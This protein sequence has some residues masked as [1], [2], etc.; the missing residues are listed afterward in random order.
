MHLWWCDL[1]CRDD[2]R[3]A[4][5]SDTINGKWCSKD[6]ISRS[7]SNSIT[8]DCVLY[9]RSLM[10]VLLVRFG[11]KHTIWNETDLNERNPFRWLCDKFPEKLVIGITQTVQKGNQNN[12]I[13]F[14][15]ITQSKTF[16]NLCP[17]VTWALIVQRIWSYPNTTEATTVNTDSI[18][19]RLRGFTRRS[20][21]KISS[22]YSATQSPPEV[23]TDNMENLHL[24]SPFHNHI[25]Y[26]M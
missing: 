18:L 7:E 9:G 5:C 22:N 20:A 25:K 8:S 17:V 6:V 23:P 15:T 21:I 14:E 19:F 16:E 10:N 3:R 26:F 11:G 12:K 24:S 1:E 2:E 13:K 4:W